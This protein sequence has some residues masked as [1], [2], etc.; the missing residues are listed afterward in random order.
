MLYMQWQRQMQ[1]SC[2]EFTQLQAGVV[3][4]SRV[5]ALFPDLLWG[6]RSGNFKFKQFTFP[7]RR[8]CIRTAASI[9]PFPA[10]AHTLNPIFNTKSCISCCDVIS[11]WLC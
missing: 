6:E 9:V 1:A 10:A 5:L 11:V 8:T 3:Q 2:K 7:G 4:A